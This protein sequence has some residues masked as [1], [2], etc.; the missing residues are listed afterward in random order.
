MLFGIDAHAQIF[1]VT[2]AGKTHPTGIVM[3]TLRTGDDVQAASPLNRP[4]LAFWGTFL[5]G[6]AAHCTQT[7]SIRLAP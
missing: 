1:D 6:F 5:R 7:S 2:S 3:D 4:V